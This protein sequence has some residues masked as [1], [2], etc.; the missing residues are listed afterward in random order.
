MAN[1]ESTI[2]YMSWWG[3]VERVTGNATN[4][5]IANKIG[6]TGP[7]IGRWK[8]GSHPDPGTAATLARAYD[9]PVLEAFIAAG[10][11]TAEEAQAR[12]TLEYDITRLDDDDLLKEVERRMKEGGHDAGQASA[13]KISENGEADG[14]RNDSATDPVLDS[15]SIDGSA[16]LTTPPVEAGARGRRIRGK[17]DVAR[18][19]E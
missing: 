6:V 13:Q 11:L 2:E 9:R 3:Y 5:D 4:A 16:T 7:S 8:S 18:D 15:A 12:P 1:T 10:F 14:D 19:N 17:G